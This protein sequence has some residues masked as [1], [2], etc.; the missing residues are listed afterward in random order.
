[1]SDTSSTKPVFGKSFNLSKIMQD[2]LQSKN[3]NEYVDCF[4]S[5]LIPTSLS[6]MRLVNLKDKDDH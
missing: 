3:L 1:M 6:S 4:R 5:D 2:K